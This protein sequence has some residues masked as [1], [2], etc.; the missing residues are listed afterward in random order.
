LVDASPI[1]QARAAPVRRS[2]DRHALILSAAERC[3]ARA[4]FHRTTMNDIAGEA[5][6]SAGNLYRYFDSKDEVVAQLCAKD[7]ADIG[8]GFAAMMDAPD[9]F[10]AFEALGRHHLVDEPRERAILIAEIW[11][12]AA[13]NPRIAEMGRALDG[14]IRSRL[15]GFVTSLSA[16]G[17]IAP[18]ADPAALVSVIMIMVDGVISNRARCPDFDPA[19]FVP[20]ISAILRHGLAGPGAPSPAPARHSHAQDTP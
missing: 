17:L 15:T 18:V 3:F 10:A 2:D 16:R 13:R 7:R 11:A 14:D 8:L 9:P 12:E 6:M 5:G 1:D 20:R 19:P 4:G